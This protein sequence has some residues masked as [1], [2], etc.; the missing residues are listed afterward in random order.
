MSD[1]FQTALQ[2]QQSGRLNQA[3]E[4]YQSLLRA[5]PN[6]PEVLQQF[7]LLLHQAGQPREGL[8]H[9]RRAAALK[10]D[11]PAIYVAAASL[12]LAA[13][14]PGEAVQAAEKALALNAALPEA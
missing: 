6:Q 14:Q 12:L 4:I 8:A 13:G 11:D 1:P 9:L 10:P 5:D 2:H 7:G 3:A